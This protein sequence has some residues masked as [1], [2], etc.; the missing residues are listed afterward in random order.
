MFRAH[1]WRT[2][3]AAD[4]LAKQE[5]AVPTVKTQPKQEKPYINNKYIL[6][7]LSYQHCLPI[8]LLFRLK[9]HHVEEDNSESDDDEFTGKGLVYDSDKEEEGPFMKVIFQRNKV[10]TNL[11]NITKFIIRQSLD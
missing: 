3:W 9:S 4:T 5:K 8:L 1:N 2:D 7:Q 10:R 11:K 6:E